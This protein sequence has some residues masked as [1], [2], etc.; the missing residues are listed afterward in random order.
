MYF[1]ITFCPQLPYAGFTYGPALSET[2]RHLV[3]GVHT[4]NVGGT[5]IIL[6]PSTK[7][8]GFNYCGHAFLV[9]KINNG[10]TISVMLL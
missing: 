8:Q 6:P 9:V 3:A 10:T 4:I 1:L 7:L 2:Q 5:P